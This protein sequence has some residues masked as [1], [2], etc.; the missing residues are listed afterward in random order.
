M[1]PFV[2]WAPATGPPTFAAVPMRFNSVIVALNESPVVLSWTA[3]Q[4]LMRRLQH[5][6]E[7][8]RI[9]ASFTEADALRPVTLLPGQRAALLLVL[10]VWSLGLDGYEPIPPELL[11]LRHAL[12]ADLD[13]SD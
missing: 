3:R 10:E 12:L 2:S 1:G 8:V 9:R 4:A 7:T 13:R 11:D 5:V 6:Q